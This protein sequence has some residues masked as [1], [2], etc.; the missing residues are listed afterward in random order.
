MKEKFP[1][2]RGDFETRKNQNSS[3]KTKIQAKVILAKC[4]YASSKSDNLFGMRIQKVEND[5][6]RTWAFKIDAER[7]KNE[8]YESSSTGGT[9]KPTQN[10]PGCPYC[11]SINLAQCRCGKSFCFKSENNNA[12]AIRLACPWC[13]QTAVYMPTERLD[14]QGGGF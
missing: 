2:M 14:L 6:V 4:P 1:K 3:K 8:G 10:Y 13:G 7:A 5:W 9:F 12:K 11:K